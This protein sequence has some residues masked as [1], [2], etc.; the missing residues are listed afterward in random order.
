MIQWNGNANSEA[1]GIGS[2]TV[3]LYGSSRVVVELGKT[4]QDPLLKVDKVTKP[5]AHAFDCFN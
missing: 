2:G 4:G 1:N 3:E 5:V